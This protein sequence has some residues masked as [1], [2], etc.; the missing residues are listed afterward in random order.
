MRP[1]PDLAAPELRRAFELIATK[2]V[3]FGIS[4][5]EVAVEDR[6]GI[7]AV[8]MSSGTAAL[9]GILRALGVAGTRVI[10]P[11]STFT[12]TALAVLDSGALP[13]IVDVTP[14]RWTLDP[15]AVRQAIDDKTSAI[16]GVN[17][18]GMPADWPSLRSIADEHELLLVEDACGSWGAKIGDEPAGTFGDAA[19]FS[20]NHT[21]LIG[22]GEGGFVV[23]PSSDLLERVRQEANF[24]EVEPDSPVRHSH[25]LGSNR[26]L[27][28]ITAALGAVRIATAPARVERA[29]RNAET[30]IA[31]ARD[32]DERIIPGTTVPVGTAGVEP[33]WHK[34]RLA[35]RNEQGTYGDLVNVF[36]WLA[37]A[38]V[39]HFTS[40]V[41][42]LCEHPVFKRRWI[43][44][45]CAAAHFRFEYTVAVGT[46]EE[47]IWSEPSWL[48]EVKER[49]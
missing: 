32:Y 43:P 19:A 18:E 36:D 14:G 24:G 2:P 38:D 44:K 46:R 17:S 31:A 20:L 12:A 4:T 49:V 41:L 25:F 33:A 11:A 47:P 6:L 39:P 48:P 8:A 27:D 45:T 13:T 7:G 26:K 30:I 21:K 1:W 28:D 37:D 3:G 22:V 40:E 42:P 23:S 9:I 34:Y 16:I 35:Y 5:L 29:R 15:D 10:V